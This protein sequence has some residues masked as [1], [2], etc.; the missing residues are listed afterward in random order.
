MGV[1][2]TR[3]TSTIK[4]SITFQAFRKYACLLLMKPMPMILTMHSIEK[5]IVKTR[6]I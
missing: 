6:S 1:M 5:I 2:L 4:K 3:L